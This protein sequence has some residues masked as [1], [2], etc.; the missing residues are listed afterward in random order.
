MN[1]SRLALLLLF[2]AAPLFAQSE[3]D[4]IRQGIA[5][6]DQGKI[7]ESIAKYREVLAKNPS[8]VTAIHELAL[9]YTMKRD[10]TACRALVE[11]ALSLPA[12]ELGPGLYTDLGNCLDAAGEWQKAVDA[13]R[14][15]LAIAPH[16]AHLGFNLAITLAAH[17]Q[18]DE[19]RQLFEQDVTA[20]PEHASGH[21][22]LARVFEAQNF[23]VPALLEYLRFLSIEPSGERAK[24]AAQRVLALMN[25]GVEKKSSK[26]INITIDSNARKEEGDFGP[27]EMMLGLLGASSDASADHIASFIAMLAET[28]ADR[29]GQEYVWHSVVPFFDEMHRLELTAPFAYVA[30]SSL[31]LKG[32]KK[33]MDANRPAV[34]RYNQWRAQSA[35]VQGIP[36][37]QKP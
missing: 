13:Y 4:I 18:L 24:F 5:L 20:Q 21:Y 2:L 17:N 36:V 7:D 25:L 6:F 8:N 28:D 33:W 26:Q 1:R 11:P 15:G 35:R 23:R 10:F 3:A 31:E 9:A 12:G 27:M 32:A 37:P 30:L 22:G 14:R 19:A 34:E 16:D 29:R